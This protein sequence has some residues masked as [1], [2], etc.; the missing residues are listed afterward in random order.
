MSMPGIQDAVTAVLITLNEAENVEAC[1]KSVL[2]TGIEKVIL[3][4]ASSTDGTVKKAT[5]LGAEC[6]VVEPRGMAFQRQV[7]ID[8]VQ[9]PY[10]F[11]VDAD[12]RLEPDC[13]TKLLQYLEASEFVG[14]AAQKVAYSSDDYWSRGWEWNNVS[15]LFTLGPKLVV[16]HPALYRTAILQAVK[17]NGNFAGPSDDTDLCFR[18]AKSGYTVAVGPGVCREVMRNTFKSFLRKTFW[19][20]NG[21]AEFFW[22]HPSRR[23]SIGSHAIRNYFFKGTARAFMAGRVDLVPFFAIYGLVR[24]A[25]FWSGLARLLRK[26]SLRV[27]RT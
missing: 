4:D 17:Y 1:I 21:D 3:V 24:W 27:Y 9:T 25:G 16:G 22:H 7:G 19:Y 8:M 5:S 6:H 18:L 12:N 15:A 26:G 20:G 11:L 10:V 14:V 13:V 2:S 23:W